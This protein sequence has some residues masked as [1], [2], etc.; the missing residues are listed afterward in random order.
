MA[1]ESWHLD[2]PCAY[3]LN[4]PRVSL[5]AWKRRVSL[6]LCLVC[7]EK[8]KLGFLRRSRAH[9]KRNKELHARLYCFICP[10]PLVSVCFSSLRI[11]FPPFSFF[12]HISILFFVCFCGL[13]LL[14]SSY[15][16][17][18][19]CGVFFCRSQLWNFLLDLKL[20]ATERETETEFSVSLWRSFF[21]FFFSLRGLV[22]LPVCPAS[23]NSCIYSS[24][25]GSWKV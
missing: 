22:D 20:S 17:L 24:T 7:R 18:S 11:S 19:F 14:S 2:S 6:S 8:K 4:T 15:T 23:F 5:P 25:R 21:C 3:R 9:T 1:Y 10:F 13:D 16:S 12:V